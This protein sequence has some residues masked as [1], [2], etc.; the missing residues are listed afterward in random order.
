MPISVAEPHALLQVQGLFTGY[1]KIII[2]YGVDLTV[3][4]TEMGAVLGANGA[5][6]TTLLPA[7]LGLLPWGASGVRFTGVDRAGRTDLRA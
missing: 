3:N 1:G 5:G 2:L 4:E 7:I 6:K